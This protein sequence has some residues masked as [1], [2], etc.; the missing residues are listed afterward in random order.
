MTGALALGS[1][2][3]S[4]L[5]QHYGHGVDLLD[6]HKRLVEMDREALVNDFRDTTDLDA[7]A[8]LGRIMLEG[9]LEWAEETGVHSNLEL[10]SVEERIVTPLFNGAVE[11]MG[12][13]DQRVRRKT[14][15]V[16]LFLDWKAQPLDEPVATPSGWTPIG[17]LAVGD[18]VLGSGHTPVKVLGVYDLGLREVFKV[19]FSD[20]TWTRAC[21]EHL[22]TVERLGKMMTIKTS[23]LLSR[24]M[25]S[26]IKPVAPSAS[27]DID[28]PIHPYVLGAWIGDAG[29]ATYRVG[30][31]FR[32]KSDNDLRWPMMVGVGSK[33]V[34]L[35]L[36]ELTGSA[37]SV[38][39]PAPGRSYTKDFYSLRVPIGFA[40]DKLQLMD[41]YSY[42]RFIPAS[43]LRSSYAQRL[44]LLR[45]L[46][47]TDGHVGSHQNTVDLSTTSEQLAHDV[48]ELVRSLGGWA[49]VRRSRKMPGYTQPDGSRVLTRHCYAT[50]IRLG[51]NPFGHNVERRERWEKKQE[52]TRA[53]YRP[54]LDRARDKLVKSVT[55][56]GVEQVRCIRVD[57][58]DQLYVTRG[59]TLTHNTSASFADFARTAAMN[60]QTLTY[61][62]LEA[63]QTDEKDRCE[64]GLFILLKKVRRTASAR[65]PFYDKIEVRHNVFALRSFWARLHG[66][67]ADLMS[68]RTALDAGADP[69]Y[70]AYPRPSRDCSW[71]CEFYGICTLFDDGSAVEHAIADAYVE[72]DPYEY[73]EP[74][75]LA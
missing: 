10:I 66:T 33:D 50:V 19:E 31:K 39:S 63:T 34:A 41:K 11:L 28:L 58:D 43:Y 6:A 16:R 51:V 74:K 3:H 59:T 29:R 38:T 73:Y 49:R 4:A 7:E 67:I 14:D 26:R 70:V 55:P 54:R 68:V 37:V 46:M 12:K 45:G 69:H 62:L 5:E 64:G 2:V 35:K 8:E 15:G 17:D 75:G 1:R 22:W 65:P 57:A 72:T 42:E 27:A 56:A 60:E 30:T 9:Y 48:A 61:Q 13:L 32:T 52:E 24:S 47:D 40:L 71:S 21:A 36:A 20:G 53:A 18:Y 44:E 23:E 25:P